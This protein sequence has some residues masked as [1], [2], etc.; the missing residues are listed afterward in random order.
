[1]YDAIQQNRSFPWYKPIKL[2]VFMT[3]SILCVL[4]AVLSPSLL[5]SAEPEI[6]A[7]VNGEPVTRGELQRMLADPRA[8]HQIKQELG[9]R[10]PDAKEMNRLG[11][12]MLIQ[13]RLL[14]QEAGRRNITVTEQEIDQEVAALRRRFKDLEGFGAW[15]QKRGINDQS[16][17][18]TVRSDL[19]TA[20]ARSALAEGVRLSEEEMRNYYETHSDELKADGDVR[21]R[22][23]AAKDKTVAEEV[24]AELRKG[25]KFASLA[26]KRSSGARAAKGGDTGWIDPRTL[27]APLRDAVATLKVG[28]IGGPL[29]KGEEFLIVGLVGR[30]PPRTKSPAEARSEI[31]KR[32]LAVKRQEAVQ[33]WLTEQEKK[34]KIEVLL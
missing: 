1:M 16:L 26:K 28:E 9:G 30:R 11:L 4:A 15:M 5:W 3:W 20:R 32:L 21:L 33:T 17:F 34:S 14:L 23:I 25:K 18:E 6:V 19:L 12:R 22:I 31:E 2:R 13:Q 7:R 8:Q 27:P 10:E 29:P 24:L